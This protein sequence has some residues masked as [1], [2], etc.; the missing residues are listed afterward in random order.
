MNNTKIDFTQRNWGIDALRAVTMCVMIFV[1][2]LWTVEGVPHYLE[3]AAPGEDFMGL[4][5]IV[6]PAFLFAVGMS[7]PFAIE[8]RFSKGM[9]TESTILH[10]LSRTLA[11]LVMGV[12]IVNS[13]AGLSSDVGY[14]GSMYLIL[15]VIGFMCIW[16]QYPRTDDPFRQYLH[17]VLKWIG[18][19]LLLYL[20][21]T[22]KGQ[23]NDYFSARWWGILGLIGWTYLVCALIY[24][25]VRERLNLLIGIWFVFLLINMVTTPLNEVHGG[26][27]LFAL[28]QPN[29]FQD[30]LKPL[31]IDNA[32]FLALTMGGIILSLLS[33]KY[34]KADN[35]VKLVFVLLTALVLFA[36]GYISRQYWILSKLTA[37]LPWI[38]YVSAIATL[39]YA[40]FY[41][42]GE[43]GWTGWF[44]II[45]PA[46]TATLT[47]YLVPYVLYAVR[48][49]TGFRLPGFL[50]TGIMGILS[51]IGFSL[52]VVWITGLL[53]KVH[54][55]L[56]I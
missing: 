5:D 46:G 1:N 18:V 44:A 11:L 9:T 41:W 28:P 26:A 40:F 55:K 38:F 14:P 13:E 22:F 7:I 6:F 50:T 56:K 15:M 43:K 24:V 19:G 52:I 17:R 35:K 49:L 31:H 8:R 36:A 21:F 3:H 27:T 42:L 51:C 12:F 29:F 48:D 33:T 2:D 45:R 39:V 10:I 37:T 54:I 25:F 20:A 32:A 30:M 4:A 16:N 34:A 53:G 23:H 47:T